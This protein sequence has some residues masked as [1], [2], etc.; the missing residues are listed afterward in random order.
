MALDRWIAVFFLLICLVYGY[1]AFFMMDGSL[2]PF[3]KRNPIWPSTFPK[4][5]SI[6]GMLTALAV[7]VTAKDDKEPDES[8][9]NYR[10]L[11]DYNIGQALF[12]MGLMVAYAVCLRPIGF[13]S[14]TTLF[15]FIGGY[16]LGERRYHILIP[17]AAIAS[18]TIWYLVQ[19]VLGIF[20]RPLPW[21]IG[22]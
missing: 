6:L 3:M 11:G 12:L 10:R 22:G 4:V 17:V 7:L 16:L 21:F 13:L 20:L 14:A 9:I 15:L 2:P 5:L 8:A 1:T 19:E 18:G